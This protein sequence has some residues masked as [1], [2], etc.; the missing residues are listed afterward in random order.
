VRDLPIACRQVLSPGP[1]L[2]NRLYGRLPSY[3][4]RRSWSDEAT[5]S[6]GSGIAL[7]AVSHANEV[8]GGKNHTRCTS[9]VTASYRGFSQGNAGIEWDLP[10]PSGFR[11]KHHVFCPAL[12]ILLSRDR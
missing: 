1:R 7:L 3:Y 6:F 2:A 11:G 8:A 5:P 4:S 9:R 12:L 10:F